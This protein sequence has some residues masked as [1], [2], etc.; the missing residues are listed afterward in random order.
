VKS[1]LVIGKILT[2]LLFLLLVS[3][4]TFA[5]FSSI[6]ETISTSSVSDDDKFVYFSNDGDVETLNV[7]FTL[8]KDGLEE[9]IEPFMNWFIPTSDL[10]FYF[11]SLSLDK[12]TSP[13]YDSPDFYQN[14][15]IWIFTRKILL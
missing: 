4:F 6:E 13:N 9:S 12:I 5:G 3:N 7:D 15:P 8:E 2:T 1:K 10:N 14:I 11:E